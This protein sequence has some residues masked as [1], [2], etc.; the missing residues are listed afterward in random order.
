V[1]GTRGRGVR[2]DTDARTDVAPQVHEQLVGACGAEHVRAA[3]DA[4]TV[5]GVRPALVVAP[6]STDETAAVLRVVAAA[7]L[8]VVTRGAGTTLDWGAPP[9]ACDVVCDVRR[10]D[11]LLEHASGDLV[12]RAQAGL[13]LATLQAEVAKAGQMLALDPVVPGAT[14]GGVLG[15]NGSGPRRLLYGSA[16]DLLLGVTVVRADGTVTRSGGKVVKNV[17]GYDLGKLYTGAYG[18]LGVVTEAVFRLHPRPPATRLVAA[19]YDDVGAATA[20]AAA[21]RRS[22]LTLSALEVDRPDATGP[23]TVSGLLEGLPDGVAARAAQ[24]RDLLGPGASEQEEAPPGWGVAPWG[25]GDVAV[26]VT[27]RLSGLSSLLEAVE[28]A[29]TR[30]GLRVA[31]RGSLGVGVLHAALAGTGGEAPDAGAVATWVEE[32]RREAARQ[33]GSLVVLRAP[34]EVRG[35]V[36]CWGPVAGLSLMR[37]VKE[38]FDPDRLLAP[39]RFVGGI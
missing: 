10:M 26:K 6:G 39:G 23:L 30:A 33:D 2:V 17:A 4:D 16:R 24:A 18:T 22:A 21:L 35:A 3:T 32:V 19:A 34:R 29:A 5:D 8:R 27:S 14:V 11:A 28:R 25:P 1:A 9:E 37:R 15:V 12:V 20:A 38:R 7:G 31:V 13:P 36:D